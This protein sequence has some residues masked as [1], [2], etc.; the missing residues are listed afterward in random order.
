MKALALGVALTAAAAAHAAAHA[1]PPAVAV[2]SRLE[3]DGYFELLSTSPSAGFVRPPAPFADGLKAVRP[4]ARPAPPATFFSRAQIL[5]RLG[6]PPALVGLENVPESVVAAAGG[7]PAVAAWLGELRALAP[8]RAAAL[9]AERAALEPAVEAFRA[10]LSSGAFTRA[11]EEY[12]GLPLPGR[13]GVILSAFHAAGGIANVVRELPDGGVEIS[14]LFGP[15]WLGR[16]PDFWTARVPGTVWHEQGHGALDPLADL[17]AAQIER[18]KP[19]DAASICYGQWRQC[20]R[21]HVVRA[22]MIRLMDRRLGPGAAAEQRR[23]EKPGGYRWLDA[24][25][26]RLKEYEADRARYPTL[27]DFYPRLLDVLD[28]KAARPGEARPFEPREE[29]SLVRARVERLAET[30]LPRVK[31]AEVR[32][33]L[34]VSLALLREPQPAVEPHAPRVEEAVK[35][36]GDGV[37]AFTAG[38]AE[39]ALRLFDRALELDPAYAEA[40]LSRATVL[41]SL[42]RPEDAL[43]SAAAAAKASR[44]GAGDY[45]PGLLADA[46]FAEAR[47]LHARPGRDARA[48]AALTEA[49]ENAPSGWSGRGEASALRAR[50]K[51]P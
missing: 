2:D 6:P 49:L 37:A 3:L 7:A 31:D 10:R 23:F 17:W 30:A 47:L 32:R 8:Q 39:E 21:E 38:R 40:S 48:A 4:P 14:S 26:E 29:T 22:V 5:M 24:M 12:A 9:E 20:V 33:R 28:A 42:G 19:A 51:R 36:A 44:R 18:A 46:L 16:S 25:E 50:L 45:Q 35:A 43:G 41:E 13:H 15:D 11:L 1:E 34:S 27:A